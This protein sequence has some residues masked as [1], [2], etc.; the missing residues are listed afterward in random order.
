MRSEWVPLGFIQSWACNYSTAI[1]LMDLKAKTWLSRKKHTRKLQAKYQK[2]L[3]AVCTL[4]ISIH[5]CYFY[6]LRAGKW[7]II[8]CWVLCIPT[9][10]TCHLQTLAWGQKV[11]GDSLLWDNLSGRKE[12]LWG[13]CHVRPACSPLSAPAGEGHLSAGSSRRSKEQYEPSSTSAAAWQLQR[14]ASP[15]IAGGIRGTS[16]HVGVGEG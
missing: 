1:F 13:V 2:E 16:L 7:V 3:A 5:L 12:R 11:G 4:I 8:L 6:F 10:N 14:I 9:S 15:H